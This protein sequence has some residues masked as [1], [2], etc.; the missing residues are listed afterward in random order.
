MSKLYIVAYGCE[1]GLGSEAEVGWQTALGL[2]AC[3]VDN[4]TVVT[5]KSNAKAISA[6]PEAA[7][8]DFVYLEHPFV[9]F[10]PHGGFSYLYYFFWQLTVWRYLRKNVQPDDIVHLL[11]FG[12]ILLP[13]FVDWLPCK[14]V[15]GPMG[16]GAVAD[17]RLMTHPSLKR[18]L[19]FRFQCVVRRMFRFM[20]LA[21]HLVRKA[22]VILVR[23]PE[24]ADMLPEFCKP[25]T[26]VLL[27]TGVAQCG[28]DLRPCDGKLRRIITVS[29]L[30]DTKNVDQVIEIYTELRKSFTELEALDIVGDGPLMPSLKKH[31]GNVPGVFFCGKVPHDQVRE[32]LLRSDLFLFAS[33]KEGGSHAL[34]EAAAVGVPI[35]CYNVSGMMV[36]PPEGGAIKVVPRKR[37]IS[38]N[39]LNLSAAV[40]KDFNENTL[41]RMISH[42]ADELREKYVWNKKCMNYQN[43]YSKLWNVKDEA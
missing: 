15:L 7:Q 38:G 34:F 41:R 28:D 20:P 35:A 40:K 33:I 5:R 10:K 19:M 14:L 24:T 32:L 9:K 1:P 18:R 13:T 16:G 22:E 4:I 21:R 36:F 11:T 25:K 43:L 26:L 23:T 27:E 29:R 6:A 17:S 37:D 8:L 30:I 2:K 39:I 12:N 31:Y 3:G 42:S